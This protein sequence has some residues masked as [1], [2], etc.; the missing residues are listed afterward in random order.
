MNAYH[1]HKKFRC[2]KKAGQ[3]SNHPAAK[4]IAVDREEAEEIFKT[5]PKNR[6]N[7]TYVCRELGLA[8][9]EEMDRGGQKNPGEWS[10]GDKCWTR[11]N[12]WND[13]DSYHPAK[14]AQVH[15]GV[16][17]TEEEKARGLTSTVGFTVWIDGKWASSRFRRSDQ[18]LLQ[19][20]KGKRRRMRNRP[21]K[22]RKTRKDK[23]Q[24]R[25]PR[26]KR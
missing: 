6:K 23:G 11:L 18:L 20:P 17:L 19:P 4:I 16:S 3:I 9:A 21:E 15:D 24:K 22:V 10:V 13:E 26:K 2:G 12:P 25:G 14:I 5:H 1:F 8:G 7:A